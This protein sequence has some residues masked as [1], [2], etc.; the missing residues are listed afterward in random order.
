M[1]TL[2]HFFKK[3]SIVLFVVGSAFNA[4]IPTAAGYDVTFTNSTPMQSSDWIPG[5]GDTFLADTKNNVGYLIHKNNSG[6]L[7]FLI[8]TG[9]RNTVNYLGR[10]YIA[11]TPVREWAVVSREIKSDR[12]TFGKQ[13]RFLRLSYNSEKT[14]YGI[15]SH[16]SIETML[17]KSERYRSMGC[18]LVSDDI[19]DLMDETFDINDGSIAVNTVYGIP[20]ALS[21]LS[22][23][24]KMNW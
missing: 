8:A 6:Y 14:P 12:T 9:Q 7:K 22:E 3:A 2:Q 5:V 15:H 16:A 1:T 21:V 13:G 24:P 4:A 17:S 19:L 18:I 23:A 11:T 20:E 10:S